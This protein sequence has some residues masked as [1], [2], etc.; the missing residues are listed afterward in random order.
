MRGLWE[1]LMAWLSDLMGQSC[2]ACE[3]PCE[4]CLGTDLDLD[5]DYTWY[6]AWDRDVDEEDF[7]I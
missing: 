3:V 5:A 2:E 4:V 6:P 1:R 7:C